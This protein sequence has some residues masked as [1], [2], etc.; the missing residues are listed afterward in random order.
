MI[1]GQGGVMAHV[2]AVLPPTDA[3]MCMDLRKFEEIELR[4]TRICSLLLYVQYRFKMEPKLLGKTTLRLVEEK[5]A[6]SISTPRFKARSLDCFI[7]SVS[8]PYDNTTL[9]ENS[10]MSVPTSVEQ[11]FCKSLGNVFALFQGFE[12]L[13]KPLGRHLTDAIGRGLSQ[14]YICRW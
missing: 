9:F 3:C 12:F 7:H 8:R 14:P 5:R 2:V 11:S 13:C 4:C 10:S 1:S 6:C